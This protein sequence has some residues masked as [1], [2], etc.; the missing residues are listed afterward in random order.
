MNA[1]DVR[2]LF[3]YNYWANARV[4]SAAARIGAEQFI[5]PAPVTTRNLRGT[6]VHQLDVEWSWRWRWQ[7]LAEG[8]ALR[9]EDF[10]TMAALAARWREDEREMRGYLTGL[11]NDDPTRPFQL[12]GSRPLLWHLMLHVVN[13]GTQQRGDAAVLL[14]RYGCSPGGLDVADFA[15]EGTAAVVVGPSIPAAGNAAS[16]SEDAP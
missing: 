15:R 5:D 16:T 14:T 4:L 11:G 6:L 3:D 1:A 2:Y 8:E 13:H 7:G 12:G 9:D 10:P